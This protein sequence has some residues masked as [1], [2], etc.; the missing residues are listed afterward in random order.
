MVLPN[1]KTT[2]AIVEVLPEPVREQIALTDD[3]RLVSRDALL[4]D[5]AAEEADAWRR[6]LASR[7]GPIVPILVPG[8]A[9]PGPV[10]DLTMLVHERTMSVNTAAAGGNASLMAVSG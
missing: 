9:R 10:C 1:L 7:P 2:R 5:G 4:F 3:V 8:P 6:V